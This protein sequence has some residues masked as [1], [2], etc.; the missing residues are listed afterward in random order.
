MS[1]EEKIKQSDVAPLRESLLREQRGVCSLCGMFL[2]AEDAALDHCHTTGRVRAVI[3]RDCNILLGKVE[4]FVGRYGRAMVVEKRLEGFLAG[5]WGYMEKDYSSN[6]LHYRHKTEEDKLLLKYRRL[7]KRS[8]KKE[9]KEKYKAL[10]K[11]I[12]DERSKRQRDD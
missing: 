5:A 8:K 4:N 3:H 7:M 10:I 9:T 6:P 1:H 2:L 11:E 12:T